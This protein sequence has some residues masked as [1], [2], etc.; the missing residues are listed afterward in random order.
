MTGAR[1]FR[2]TVAPRIFSSAG[3]LRGKFRVP[4]G[5]HSGDRFSA[6]NTSSVRQP[7]ASQLGQPN[8]DKG[9]ESFAHVRPAGNSSTLTHPRFCG[10]V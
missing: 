8:E 4:T 9:K 2:A 5:D 3:P 6:D 10:W 7:A 1:S